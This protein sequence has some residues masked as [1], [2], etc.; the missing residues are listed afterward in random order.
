[1][2][3]PL[4]YITHA[5]HNNHKWTKFPVPTRRNPFRIVSQGSWSD[6]QN[7]IDLSLDYTL[8]IEGGPQLPK[9]PNMDI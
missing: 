9:T 1:M 8:W 7:N 4:P 2:T 6:Y 5:T 3:F